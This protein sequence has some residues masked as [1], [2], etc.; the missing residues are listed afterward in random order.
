MSAP[1]EKE[2]RESDVPR[3]ASFEELS[4]Y[5]ATLVDREHDYGTCVYAMS[6]AATAAF[7]LVASRLGVTGFQASCADMDILRRTRHLNGPFMLLKGEDAL[8]PQY[9]LRGRLDEFLRDIQPWLAEQATAKLQQPLEHVHPSVQR[10]WQQ[11]AA[12]GRPMT[13]A[14]EGAEASRRG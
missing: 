6:M 10:H 14:E 13:H 7:N 4:A 9:D 1:T 5:I 3:L 11:I 12:A 8:F 2:M